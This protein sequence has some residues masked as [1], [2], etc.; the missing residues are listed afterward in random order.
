MTNFCN[1]GFGKKKECGNE[2]LSKFWKREEY[3][4]ETLSVSEKS[5]RDAFKKKSS[6]KGTLVLI[7]GEG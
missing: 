2:S 4:Y 3:H 6:Y 7:W 1:D 5:L